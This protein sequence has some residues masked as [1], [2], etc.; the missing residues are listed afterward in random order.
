MKMLDYEIL[1]PG[2]REIGEDL[3]LLGE[4]TCIEPLSTAVPDA[5]LPEWY[6][7]GRE[8]HGVNNAYLFL[9]DQTFL[10]DTTTT[11]QPEGVLEYLDAQLGDRSLD[12]L[13]IS[14]PE[15]PHAGNVP[16][17]LEAYPEATLV[18][19]D[20]G[21]EHELYGLSDEDRT[22]TGSASSS[23]TRYRTTCRPHSSRRSTG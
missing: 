19:P 2:Y 14:H 4:C 16:E 15:G 20:N 12:Y 3:Y 7:P 5:E 17:I 18:A 6:Q 22:T 23:S 9:D 13:A 11:A 1:N 21:V 10:F 8:L